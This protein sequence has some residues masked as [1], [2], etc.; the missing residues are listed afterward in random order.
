MEEIERKNTIAI[1]PS[2]DRSLQELT[3]AKKF[4]T[5]PMSEREGDR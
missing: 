2:D 1:V 3:K 5:K 4:K